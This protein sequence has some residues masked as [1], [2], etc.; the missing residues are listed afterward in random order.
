MQIEGHQ[1]IGYKTDDSNQNHG[2]QA[3]NPATGKPIAEYTFFNASETQ[4]DQAIELADQ[5]FRLYKQTSAQV[6]AH[7]LRAI[8]DEIDQR[9]ELLTITAGAETGLPA[10]RLNGERGRTIGQLRMFADWIEEGSYLNATIDTALPDR[11]PLP[12]A[13]IRRMNQPLGPVVVFGA[14]NFP[15]AFSVA[16]GDTA[17]ALA[18]GC[19]VIVK[20]HPAH[21]ATSELVGKAIQVA[22]RKTDMPE[23]VFS[24]IQGN[25]NESGQYLVTHPLV[26]AV[27]FT[28]SFRGGKALYD[29]AQTRPHPIP[30]FAEMGSTNPVFILPGALKKRGKEIASGLSG[31]VNLGAGQFCTNPGVFMIRDTDE[32]DSF[33]KQITTAFTS[34]PSQVMLTPGIHQAYKTGTRRLANA[35]HYTILA[36][37]PDEDLPGAGRP[38]LFRASWSAVRNDPQLTEEV[39]GPS[40][41]M[42]NAGTDEEILEFAHS[43]EGHLTATIHA[44]D[45]DDALLDQLLPILQEKVGRIIFNAYPTG[46]EVCHAMVHGGPFPATTDSATTSVGTASIFRFLRPVCYQDIPN[47][48]LPDALKKEN[49]LGILRLVNGQYSREATE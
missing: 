13:D 25:S 36:Q 15:L 26:R 40:S 21:P 2:F 37:G 10:G 11:Q 23:G 8:A 6:R 35:G 31:S 9:G 17:S 5:A 41:I 48:Y 28:G 42:L 24:L 29:L 39:F 45:S 32:T 22:A 49:P 16:G 14:S 46:V 47:R 12:R 44:E 3:V 34:L 19:P 43:L 1:I 33:I 20:A 30:V 38:T 4:M 7:F 27:G 18:A